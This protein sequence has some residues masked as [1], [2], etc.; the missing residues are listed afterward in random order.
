MSH[1]IELEYRSERDALSVGAISRSTFGRE[2][3]VLW[4]ISSR[5]DTPLTW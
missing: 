3:C 1:K 5:S 2:K 4:K